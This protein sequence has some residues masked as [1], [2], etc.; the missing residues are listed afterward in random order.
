LK[1]LVGAVAGPAASEL[2]GGRLEVVGFGGVNSPATGMNNPV[3]VLESR[4]VT[5]WGRSPQSHSR[6][7][8]WR[9]RRE[10]VTRGQSGEGLGRNE[11]A[12]CR[13]G[14]LPGGGAEASGERLQDSEASDVG[15]NSPMTAAFARSQSRFIRL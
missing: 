6:T 3:L 15:A 2:L 8:D 1:V 14:E 7:T 10:K 9:F 11:A 5:W 13:S 4:A 12:R